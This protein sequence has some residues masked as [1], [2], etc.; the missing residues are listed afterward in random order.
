MDNKMEGR[1]DD[2]AAQNINLEN[3][4]AREELESSS[5]FIQQSNKQKTATSNKNLNGQLRALDLG[6]ES[7]ARWTNEE[8][9]VLVRLYKVYGAR[10]STISG[11]FNDRSEF[12]VKNHFYYLK[13]RM[14]V[15]EQIKI[16]QELKHNREKRFLL[17][18]NKQAVNCEEKMDEEA[19][20]DSFFADYLDCKISKKIH[21]KREEISMSTCESDKNIDFQQDR[22]SMLKRFSEIIEDQLAIKKAKVSENLS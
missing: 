4:T 3:N 11:F 6:E 20:V 9:F 14:P 12:S 7:K 17:L 18:P 10:W 13:K 21:G 5:N 15:N 19:I 8:N 2:Q 1:N 22:L 16:S